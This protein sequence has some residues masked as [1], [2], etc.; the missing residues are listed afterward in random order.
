MA[1]RVSNCTV[2]VT[3]RYLLTVSDSGSPALSTTATLTLTLIDV[4]DEQPRFDRTA[5]FLN[6]AENQPPGTVIGRLTATDADITPAFS[7][8]VFDVVRPG[9]SGNGGDGDVF[10][11]DRKSGEI[12]TARRLDREE[13]AVYVFT[14]AVSNDVTVT[15]RDGSSD[16]TESTADVTVYVDDVNDQRPVFVFP[17]ARR[18][19]SVDLTTPLSLTVSESKFYRAEQIMAVVPFWNM[20]TN[21]HRQVLII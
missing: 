10:E 3:Y 9:G 8:I 6:V 19:R 15:P 18:G 5:Y 2:S 12:R 21:C 17:G 16:T 13:R 7:R 14:V 4:N 20:S 1:Y 11:V